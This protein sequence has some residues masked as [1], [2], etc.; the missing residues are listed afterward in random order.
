M[1]FG[2]PAGGSCLPSR[3]ALFRKFTSSMMKPCSVAASPLS[4]FARSTT[5]AC[6]W[7]TS[8]PVLVGT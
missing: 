6:F 7:I 3:S 1:M 8:S 4:I 5:Q 2:A